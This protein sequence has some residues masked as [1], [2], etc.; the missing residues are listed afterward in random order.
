M[1]EITELLITLSYL[2]KKRILKALFKSKFVFA[3]DSY[4]HGSEV[5]I[6]IEHDIIDDAS[7]Y[8]LFGGNKATEI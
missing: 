6:N 3:I 4:H 2:K 8:N 7:M 5:R 1:T